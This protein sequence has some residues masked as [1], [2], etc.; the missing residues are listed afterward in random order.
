MEFIKKGMQYK[1]RKKMVTYKLSLITKNIAYLENNYWNS[2][3]RPSYSYWY[4]M[5]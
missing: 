3:I 1:F 4:G 2:R 5:L